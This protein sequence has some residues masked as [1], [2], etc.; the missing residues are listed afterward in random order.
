[1]TTTAT[2]PTTTCV[3]CGKP[4]IRR[5]DGVCSECAPGYY[6]TAPRC[7]DCGDPTRAADR[8]CPDCRGSR[9]AADASRNAGWYDGAT[10]LPV[11]PPRRPALRRPRNG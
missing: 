4:R 2:L 5:T 1:M 11:P 6:G 10:G 9:I 3:V 8:L 7:Q